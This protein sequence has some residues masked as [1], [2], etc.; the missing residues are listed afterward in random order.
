M[1]NQ[2][3]ESYFVHMALYMCMHGHSLIHLCRVSMVYTVAGEWGH[4]EYQWWDVGCPH[5]YWFWCVGGYTEV[6]YV[7]MRVI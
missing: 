6:S 3:C 4:R 2:Y 7:A 5:I 1:F